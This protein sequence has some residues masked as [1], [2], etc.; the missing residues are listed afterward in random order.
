MNVVILIRP[1]AAKFSNPEI[2]TTCV[3]PAITKVTIIFPAIY[4][5]VDGHEAA[6]VQ[7]TYTQMWLAT[8]IYLLI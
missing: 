3:L 7:R 8:F 2:S 1:L 6:A 5:C 4:V